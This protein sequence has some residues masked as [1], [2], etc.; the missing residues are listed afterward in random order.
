MSKKES[1]VN[2]T[3]APAV[4][5]SRWKQELEQLDRLLTGR[6]TEAEAKEY[7]KS[8]LAKHDGVV[9]TIEVELV[10]GRAVLTST[11][12]L[13]RA[14]R[15][16]LEDRIESLE[17]DLAI[18][19]KLREASILKCGSGIRAAKD[20]DKHRP[21]WQELRQRQQTIE[22]ATGFARGRQPELNFSMPH[23]FVG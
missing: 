5:E 10:R 8:E 22:A 19:R 16:R 14:D 6:L 7:A 23:K 12:F 3:E 17:G 18:A 2:T 15:K 4:D 11:S 9:H 1:V 13:P 20:A 21:R